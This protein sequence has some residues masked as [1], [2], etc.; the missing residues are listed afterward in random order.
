[1][2]VICLLEYYSFIKI[3]FNNSE[4][5][6][7]D[8]SVDS[9]DVFLRTAN[10]WHENKEIRRKK[11]INNNYND[12]DKDNENDKDN[13]N[14]ND[15]DNGKDTCEESK[16]SAGKRRR[17]QQRGIDKD[18]EEEEEKEEEE[19]EGEEEDEVM[20]Y[21]LC[22]IQSFMSHVSASSKIIATTDTATDTVTDTHI[23]RYSY[24]YSYRCYR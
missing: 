16:L 8:C 3:L 19:E 4:G 17:S 13:Y 12:K 9:V 24:N 20:S 22:N 23:Y 21:L 5:E 15:R 11:E 14:D 1:M 2:C 10:S 6:Y 7:S 18:F